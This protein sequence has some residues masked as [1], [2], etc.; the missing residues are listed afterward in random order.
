MNPSSVD[1]KNVLVADATLG[2][3][4]ATNLFIGQEPIN[5]DD[6]VTIFD[7][8]GFPPDSF[9]DNSV[10]YFRPSIQ[11]RV[12]NTDYLVGWALINNIKLLLHDRAQETRNS[13]LYSAVICSSEPSL[14]DWD[15]N[16]RARFV[17]TFDIQ[18]R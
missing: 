13:T 5:P 7:T 15:K 12:R 17:T 8:P 16:G 14:L 9:Y 18:R 6:C 10:R 1:M 3:V 4:F 2:L 11:V